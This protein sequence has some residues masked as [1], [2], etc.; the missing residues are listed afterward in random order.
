M[1]FIPPPPPS[2]WNNL[3]RLSIGFSCLH[4]FGH[5]IEDS[6]EPICDSGND[7]KTTNQFLRHLTSFDVQR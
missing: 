6:T 5:H 2:P 7:L 3:K 1:K 4:R